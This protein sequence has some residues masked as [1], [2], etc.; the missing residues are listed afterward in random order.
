MDLTYRMIMILEVV[1][2][3]NTDGSLVDLD[4][5]IERVDYEVTKPAI[6]F[7]LRRMVE[8]GVIEKFGMEKRRGKSRVIYRGTE[9]GYQALKVH[10]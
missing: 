4:Q 3:R 9:L 2:K 8:H 1:L 10:R 5:I 6:Q 7:T